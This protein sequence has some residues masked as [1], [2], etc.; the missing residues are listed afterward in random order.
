MYFITIIHNTRKMTLGLLLCVTL[1][2]PR[3]LATPGSAELEER[4]RAVQQAVQQAIPQ[5]DTLWQAGQYAEAFR[6]LFDALAT[7]QRTR[8]FLIL[9]SEPGLEQDWLDR[10]PLTADSA[11]TTLE[12]RLIREDDS[13]V[14]HWFRDP[15]V[16]V[17]EKLK[18]LNE[19]FGLA[20][21]DWPDPDRVQFQGTYQGALV[22]LM[23]SPRLRLGEK[24]DILD[25]LRDAV[26]TEYTGATQHDRILAE[27]RR[28]RAEA[29]QK[30]QA[31]QYVE[32]F[33]LIDEAEQKAREI[34]LYLVSRQEDEELGKQR[35]FMY[36]TFIETDVSPLM[37]MFKN[38]KIPTRK[39]QLFI[40]DLRERVGELAQLPGSLRLAGQTYTGTFV[41]L[42][43][44][45][46]IDWLT[47]DNML[48]FIDRGIL[49]PEP[50]YL[51]DYMWR[52]DEGFRKLHAEYDQQKE[53]ESDP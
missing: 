30:V 39:R 42:L 7:E 31:Q 48:V 4:A 36:D 22:H 28:L 53:K 20:A 21:S 6:L 3:L 5:A 18:T 26:Q 37:Q 19:L 8:Q 9:A 32:A 46:H 51:P 24:T 12:H 38:T 25:A 23:A 16:P 52:D 40:H 2:V 15:A 41:D 45:P 47:K 1:V 50:E 29:E 13:P 33:V 10:F 27:I 17:E 14:L 44:H 43:T 35:A 11:L 34:K 49:R